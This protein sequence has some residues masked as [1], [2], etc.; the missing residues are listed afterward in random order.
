MRISQAIRQLWSAD[1]AAPATSSVRSASVGLAPVSPAAEAPLPTTTATTRGQRAH[2]L[3][4]TAVGSHTPAV[5]AALLGVAP[6][7]MPAAAAEGPREVVADPS[8]QALAASVLFGAPT[9]AAGVVEHLVS[10][11]EDLAARRA[12][13]PALPADASPTMRAIYRDVVPVIDAGTVPTDLFYTTQ[14]SVQDR[15]LIDPEDIFT[16]ISQAVAGAKHD[17]ALQTFAWDIESQP[18]EAFFAGLKELQ[19]TRKAEGAT[20]PVRVRIAIDAMDTA[21][22]GNSPTMKLMVDVMRRARDEGLDA[23]FVKVE[24]AAHEHLGPGSLHAKTVVVDGV[25]AVVTGANMNKNDNWIEG[26]HDAGFQLE[27]QVARGLLADFDDAWLNSR[28]WVGGD[29]LPKP[30]VGK[31]VHGDHPDTKPLF[32]TP[33]SIEHDVLPVPPGRPGGIPMMVL[34]KRPVES[35]FE[36]N[37]TRS[38]L[39][40][41]VLSALRHTKDVVRIQTPNLNDDDLLAELLRAMDRGVR[42]DVVL[43]KNYEDFAESMPGQNGTNS[44]VVARLYQALDTRGVPRDHLRIRE[45]SH[46]GIT[47]VDGNA[48]RASHVKMLV[49]DDQRVLVTSMN[50]DTQSWNHSR[51]IGVLVDDA[52]VT[53][54]WLDQLFWPDFNRSFAAPQPPAGPSS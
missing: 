13:I 27:G 51:E 35:L 44:E 11:R 53:K 12:V 1:E 23:R 48:P 36:N 54:S 52:T 50:M 4:S 14:N 42:V 8:A 43:T 18:V 40:R 24:V 41:A 19:A 25:R 9:P 28:V 37:N 17:V 49:F 7:V 32:V 5:A 20:T 2:V 6:M 31:T 46:D 45:Y 33:Q 39:D 15:V 26:E 21:M 29:T 38:P 3:P 34:S 16:H 30:R 47:P 10:T 22:N